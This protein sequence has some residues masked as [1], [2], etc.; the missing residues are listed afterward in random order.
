MLGS[1]GVESSHVT[2]IS[3]K[4]KHSYLWTMTRTF[5]TLPIQLEVIRP[6]DVFPYLPRH[7]VRSEYD[8]AKLSH[9]LESTPGATWGSIAEILPNPPEEYRKQWARGVRFHD[10]AMPNPSRWTPKENKRLTTVKSTQRERE[11]IAA[12]LKR[13]R[14]DCGRLLS[15]LGSHF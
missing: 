9:T 12:A 15:Y 4:T 2:R 7:T 1:K 10:R 11:T 14:T 5:S 6:A 8:S 13:T 3:G